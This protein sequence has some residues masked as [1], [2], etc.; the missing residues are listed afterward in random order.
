MNFDLKEAKEILR[1]TPNVLASLLSGLSENWIR[2]DEGKDTWSPFDVVG[3]LID[4]ERRDWLERVQIIRSQGDNLE[5]QPFD[6]FEHLTRNKDRSL[7]ELLEEFR[8]LRDQNLNEIDSISNVA[9]LE[10]KGIHPAFGEVSLH[11]L[12]STW[13]VHDLNH[14]SQITRVMANRYTQD[15]GPWK[16]YLRILSK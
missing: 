16:E 11:Q 2:T 10:L 9:E 3:H 1:N 6:R 8:R 4:G 12:L 7:E 5:F 13:V 14:I 15:V